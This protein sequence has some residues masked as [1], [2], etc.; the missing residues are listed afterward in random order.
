M[1]MRIFKVNKNLFPV[2]EKNQCH[3]DHISF[4]FLSI[5]YVVENV[6][7]ETVGSFFNSHEQI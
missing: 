2:G 4:S 3:L 1:C 6:S 7:D 5:E